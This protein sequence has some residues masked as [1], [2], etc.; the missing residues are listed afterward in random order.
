MHLHAPAPRPS[1]SD[2]AA[3]MMTVFPHPAPTRCSALPSILT[4][5][6]V[7]PACMSP[8]WLYTPSAMWIVVP[9]DAALTAAWIVAYGCSSVP[10]ADVGSAPAS[11]YRSARANIAASAIRPDAMS[12]LVFIFV[13]FLVLIF[14]R[15]SPGGRIRGT[16]PSLARRSNLAALEIL[17]QCRKECQAVWPSMQRKDP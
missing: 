5:L 10:S 7:N 17:L 13:S 11:T 1:E 14:S 15:G 8:P 6:E 2:P 12:F 4:R 16:C 3:P 9:A